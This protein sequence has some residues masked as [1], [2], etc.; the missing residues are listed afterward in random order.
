MKMIILNI[1]LQVMIQ[2]HNRHNSMSIYL[3]ALTIP[4]TIILIVGKYQKVKTAFSQ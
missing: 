3:A 4:D 1:Y 2:P